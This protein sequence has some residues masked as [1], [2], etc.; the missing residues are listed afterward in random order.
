METVTFLAVFV[1]PFFYPQNG[2]CQHWPEQPKVAAKVAG[3]FR[4]HN[5]AFRRIKARAWGGAVLLGFNIA[6]FRAFYFGR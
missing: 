5:C 4:A 3:D 1:A 6:A 2:E